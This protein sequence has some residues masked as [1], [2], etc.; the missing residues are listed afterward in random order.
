MYT[1][2]SLCSFSSDNPPRYDQTLS[3]S[4][5]DPTSGRSNNQGF[6]GLTVSGDG[7]N[8]F[9]LLQSA[10]VQDGGLEKTSNRYARMLKYDI[11]EDDKPRYAKEFVVPLPG[12]TDVS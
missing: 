8:L 6:E 3:P 11:S 4:P 12:Y 7:K 1:Y 9:A 10:T 5:I 2:T